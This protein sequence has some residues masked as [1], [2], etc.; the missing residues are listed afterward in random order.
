MTKLLPLLLAIGIAFLMWYLSARRLTGELDRRSTP[1]NDPVLEPVLGR[2]A[3]A[4]DLKRIKVHIY[5][6]EPINGL[7]APDGR[8]FITRGFFNAYRQGK[9]SAEEIASVVAHELGHVALGHSRRRMVD[10]TGA[11]ALRMGLAMILGRF[12]PFVGAYIAHFIAQALQAA[13]SRKDE[14]EADEYAAALMVKAGLGVRPQVELLAKLDR[15]TGTMG[16]P[17]AWLMSHPRTEDRIAAIKAAEA[18]W[19]AGSDAAR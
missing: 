18:R 5:E 10:F 8:V 12:I 13:L 4:L 3:R 16:R 1:L 9:V 11:N 17:P 6:V 15:M 19:L 2:L 7:A 14:Y